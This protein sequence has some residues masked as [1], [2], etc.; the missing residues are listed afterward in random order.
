[1]MKLPVRCGIAIL[2]LIASFLC[3]CKQ[4]TY[5]YC[6]GDEVS[7]RQSPDRESAK[8][9]TLK[10]GD[11]V[12]LME[13]G[14]SRETI[15]LDGY[16]AD[17]PWYRIK[18][19]GGKTGWVYGG[20][21]Y[22]HLFTARKIDYPG[23]RVIGWNQKDMFAY[24][25]AHE[26]YMGDEPIYSLLIYDVG[27]NKE[28]GVV[29]YDRVEFKK[30]Q[31]YAAAIEKVYFDPQAPGSE[32]KYEEFYLSHSLPTFL[33]I[34][35]Y[36]IHEVLDSLDFVP[37]DGAELHPL[38]VICNGKTIEITIDTRKRTD[39]FAD[40]IGRFDV[41]A[42]DGKE[43]KVVLSKTGYFRNVKA[44]GFLKNPLTGNPVLAVEYIEWS[45]YEILEH[46]FIGL[47]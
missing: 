27:V 47:R 38:P 9:D 11:K 15:V 44:P 32:K 19:S 20:F 2:A 34:N 24:I 30:V 36:K 23:Y 14:K 40:M 43:A 17:K 29:S 21:L 10:A 37:V 41:V 46:E 13:E 42:I 39:S 16:K 12:A 5:L 31:S 28:S 1:M 6:L 45:G 4:E 18:T 22:R 7:I 25:R 35:R 8:I 33:Y 3:G 26:N